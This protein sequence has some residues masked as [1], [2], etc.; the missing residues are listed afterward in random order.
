[1]IL[2]LVEQVKA[3]GKEVVNRAEDIVGKG[4]LLIDLSLMITIQVDEIPTL[5]VTRTYAS[6]EVI[7][8]AEKKTMGEA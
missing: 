8:L 7:K 3:M 1:M 6:H 2:D 5:E 4:D